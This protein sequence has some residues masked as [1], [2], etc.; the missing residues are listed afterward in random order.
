M[1]YDNVSEPGR[2]SEQNSKG[3]T[4]LEMQEIKRC[5]RKKKRG[6]LMEAPELMTITYGAVGATNEQIIELME[7]RAEEA[8]AG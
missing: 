2:I 3:L 6:E 4:D 7:V 1:S 8:H 5:M